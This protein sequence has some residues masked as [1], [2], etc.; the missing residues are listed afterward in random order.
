MLPKDQLRNWL[1]WY[2]CRPSILIVTG[3]DQ[4]LVVKVDPATGA[5]I[6]GPFKVADIIDGFT[7]Y[8]LFGQVFPAK[9]TRNLHLWR[10]DFNAR[11]HPSFASP[12][13]TDISGPNFGAI[14]STVAP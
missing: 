8:P 2:V 13:F 9:N 12:A 5:R 3:S 6:A 10:V 7:D 14:T 4:Y 11:N 1:S